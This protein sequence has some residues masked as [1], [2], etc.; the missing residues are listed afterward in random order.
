MY[1]F[2]CP[3]ALTVCEWGKGGPLMLYCFVVGRVGTIK[4]EYF[5]E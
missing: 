5:D 1:V 2:L 4:V 3:G